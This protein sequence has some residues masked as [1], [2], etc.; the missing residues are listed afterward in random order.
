M[1]C[2]LLICTNTSKHCSWK[3]CFFVFQNCNTVTVTLETQIWRN[4]KIRTNPLCGFWKLLYCNAWNAENGFWKLLY[5]YIVTLEPMV[6]SDLFLLT[7]TIASVF[8]R[9]LLAYRDTSILRFC[10]SQQFWRSTQLLE[11]PITNCHIIFLDLILGF[12]PWISFLDFIL[13]F[14]PSFSRHGRIKASF[15]LLI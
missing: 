15:I 14:H 4:K 13:G 10:V 11:K 8:L 9:N 3:R 2:N 6:S 1:N 12:H 5:C 7:V